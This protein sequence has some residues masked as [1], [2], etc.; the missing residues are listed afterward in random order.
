[1]GRKDEPGWKQERRVKRQQKEADTGFFSAKENDFAVEKQKARDLRS[2]PWWKKKI[3]AGKCY[4]CGKDFHPSEL[5]MD[6]K[7]PLA[8]GG[9]SEKIN[10]VTAC[11]DCNNKKKYLLPVEWEEYLNNIK[12]TE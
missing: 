10:I 2:S 7:I 5:T 6:H 1:M 12:N 11:K 4:Y 8:R 9:T 3:A